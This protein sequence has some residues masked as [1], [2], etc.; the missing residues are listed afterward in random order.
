M[1]VP[2]G[3]G[4]KI[5]VA[6]REPIAARDAKIERA[7][8]PPLAPVQSVIDRDHL[9]RMTFGEPSLEREVLQLFDRQAEMLLA[10][11]AGAEPAV[12]A[13]LAHTLKG[14]AQGIGAC[15]VVAAAEQVERASCADGQT[16]CTRA[17]TMLVLAVDEARV[18][19]G[20]LLR[21]H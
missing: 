6:N 19:I 20:D 14:S 1:K 10:R 3:T 16:G 15:H 2:A 5:E 4:M 12:L 9:A 11:M 8:A 7:D 21:G 17:L 13:A 18:A